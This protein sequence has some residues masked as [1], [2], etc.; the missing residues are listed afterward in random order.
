MSTVVEMGRNQGFAN[1]LILRIDREPQATHVEVDMTEGDAFADSCTTYTEVVLLAGAARNIGAHNRA[2]EFLRER[3]YDS[4][5]SDDHAPLSGRHLF[6]LTF[7]ALV[8]PTQEQATGIRP[9]PSDDEFFT[10]RQQVEAFTR[11]HALIS[12]SYTAVP[13]L[14][15]TPATHDGPRHQAAWDLLNEATPGFGEAVQRKATRVMQDLDHPP[16]D[17][18]PLDLEALSQRELARQTF[19]VFAN[20]LDIEVNLAANPGHGNIAAQMDW[21]RGKEGSIA[22][23]KYVIVSS[24]RRLFSHYISLEHGIVYRSA[25]PDT[26]DIE[27]LEEWGQNLID[28]AKVA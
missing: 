14:V 15:N 23:R 24:L 25:Q 10:Y 16:A 4:E 6:S 9:V 1:T 17:R 20:T 13:K 2:G 7:P 27:Q 19:R 11:G 18:G 5:F 28:F 8:A 3:G 22:A 12:Q 26:V 21:V